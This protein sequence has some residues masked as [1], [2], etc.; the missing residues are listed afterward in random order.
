VTR[1]ATFFEEADARAVAE[2]LADEGWSA[3]VTRERFAGEDDDEDHPWAVLTSAPSEVVGPLAEEHDGWL[4]DPGD[5][6][7]GEGPARPLDLPRG[8][9]R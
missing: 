3:E 4:D 6:P 7:G 5:D 9:R 2:R 8:P 1:R